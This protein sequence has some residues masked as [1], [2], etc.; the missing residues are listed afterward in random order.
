LITPTTNATIFPLAVFHGETRSKE[1]KYVVLICER[2]RDR[3][4]M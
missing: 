4:K 3:W 1:D 2:K